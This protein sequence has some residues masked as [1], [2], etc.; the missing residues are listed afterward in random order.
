IKY[1]GNNNWVLSNILGSCFSIFG[2][3]NAK[4]NSFKTGFIMLTGLFFY[5]IYFVFGTDIMVT[6][7]TNM[8]IP[9]KILIP[10]APEIKDYDF[11][12]LIPIIKMSMLGLGD[13]V[14]PGIFISLCLR[15]DLF[16]YHES[17]KE[18]TE[19]HHL[20]A[21]TKSYFHNAIISYVFGLSLTMLFLNVFH[22]AQPALLYLCPSIIIF[23][24][25][26]AWLSND[27]RLLW[28]YTEGDEEKDEDE[29][30]D[31]NED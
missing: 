25:V 10:R 17:Q 11:T 31:K 30:E 14:I 6:V 5:D 28:N 3:Q 9:V 19:F 13:I 21:Y 4:I 27:L 16:K 8:E 18:K 22:A 29:D 23:T 26:K 7:A 1:N 12:G 15:F 2:I 20:N 24:V